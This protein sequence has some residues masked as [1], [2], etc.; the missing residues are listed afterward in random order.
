MDKDHLILHQDLTTTEGADSLD[1]ACWLLAETWVTSPAG[2]H[3]VL[4]YPWLWPNQTSPTGIPED[5]FL[6]ILNAVTQSLKELWQKENKTVIVLATCLFVIP[7]FRY[8]SQ[9]HILQITSPGF[10]L[11]LTLLMPP[12]GHSPLPPHKQNLCLGWQC[13]Q[14]RKLISQPLC[15]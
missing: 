12:N 9:R 6:K 1:T 5:D 10:L 7:P 15:N 14:V 8:V 2:S 4:C 13:A 3:Q 11:W